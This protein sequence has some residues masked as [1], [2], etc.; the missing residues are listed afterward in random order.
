MPSAA[1]DVRALGVDFLA[2][3]FHK[4]LA[5]FGSGV[6]Y[7]RADLLQ[8]ALPF[9]YGGDMVAEGGVTAG[10]VTYNRLPW[11]YAAGTPNVL[12]VI[13]SAQALRL[14]ADLVVPASRGY[15]RSNR[16]LPRSTIEETMRRVG[17]HTRDL[18]ARALDAVRHIDGLILH[19][20][21]HAADRA[22]LIAF[23]LVGRSP[24]SVAEALDRHGVESRAGC[25]CATLAH[26]ALGLDPPASCRLS[27]AVYNT[28]EDVDR[29]TGALHRVSRAGRGPL[30]RL[31]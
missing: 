2:F 20:P 13:V 9:L 31:R 1:V 10:H 3:S 26:H 14:L 15:F 8:A 23:N 22:P 25:H 30:A 17:S 29:A 7:G 6:L 27:F 12:G 21:D 11:K 28:V 16:P 18:T 19:G 4:L 24:A 5:P